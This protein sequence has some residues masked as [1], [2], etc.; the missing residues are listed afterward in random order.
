MLF[1]YDKSGLG[2][3]WK[4]NSLG[5]LKLIN[6]LADL[7]SGWDSITVISKHL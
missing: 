6:S 2:E 1:F 5:E 7:N 4:I 3:F